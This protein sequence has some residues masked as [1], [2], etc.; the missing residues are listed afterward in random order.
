MQS[1]SNDISDLYNL[2]GYMV[3]IGTP[4]KLLEGTEHFW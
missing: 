1:L 3:G 2:Q 4:T